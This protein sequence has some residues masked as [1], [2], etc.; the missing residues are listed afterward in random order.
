MITSVAIAKHSVQ[1]LE[2]G[3]ARE[4]KPRNALSWYRTVL[5]FLDHHVLD[6]DWKRPDLL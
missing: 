5:A 6:Q 2:V 3:D 1:P 4:L